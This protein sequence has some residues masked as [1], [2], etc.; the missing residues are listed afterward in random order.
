[1]IPEEVKPPDAEPAK[2]E[3]T[4]PADLPKEDPDKVRREV[5]RRMFPEIPRQDS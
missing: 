4:E 1:M 5:F 2:R 3:E